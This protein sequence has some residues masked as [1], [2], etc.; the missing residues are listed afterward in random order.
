MEILLVLF[1]SGLPI[2]EVQ[3]L[4]NERAEQYRGVKGLL[5]KLWV[6]DKS[7]GHVGGIYVFD[8]REN[9]EAF[10]SSDLAKSIGDAYKPVE[11]PTRRVFDVILALYEEKQHLV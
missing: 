2:N 6:H 5:Q 9:L 10:R 3:R 7:T 4:F 1:K 8:S 11:P